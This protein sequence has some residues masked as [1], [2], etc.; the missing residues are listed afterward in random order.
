[1]SG[2]EKMEWIDTIYIDLSGARMGHKKEPPTVWRSFRCPAQFWSDLLDH[3]LCIRLVFKVRADIVFRD[4][5]MSCA[6]ETGPQQK[7]LQGPIGFCI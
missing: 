2:L 7:I 4:T 1:M 3:G 5:V 6:R